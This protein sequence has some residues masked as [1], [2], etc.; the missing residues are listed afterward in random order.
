MALIKCP[1][2]GKEISDRAK[3]CINCG[4]PI[5]DFKGKDGNINLDVGKL[6]IKMDKSKGT[7]LAPFEKVVEIRSLEGDFLC[8]L[9]PGETKTVKI[10]KD[11]EIYA[12]QSWIPNKEKV[13][14]R[15]KNSKNYVGGL[16]ISA[17]E[18]TRVQVAMVRTGIGLTFKTIMNKVDVID[19]E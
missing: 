10:D 5:E 18:T 16:K 12:I 11:M 15:A 3:A 1:E 6:I 7:F 13:V 9:Y 19:S 17:K 2:C 14:E 4:C 8:K